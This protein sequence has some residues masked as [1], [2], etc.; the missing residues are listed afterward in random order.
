MHHTTKTDTATGAIV[1]GEGTRFRIW[2]P[3]S[4]SVEI[5]V[6]RDDAVD[7][8]DG[9]DRVEIH[10]LQP[11]AGGWFGAHVPGVAAGDRY[12]LR[13]NGTDTSPDP[14][15]RFQPDGVHGASEVVDLNAF[16]W[17][18]GN[19]RGRGLDEMVI[20]ELHVGTA[21]PAG[22][23]DALIER[24]PYFVE[25]GVTALEI[26]PVAEFP[27]DRNWGYDGVYLFAPTRA[28]GGPDA[29]RRFIDA[30]HGHGLAVIL[31][32]VY[33]H[34]G[35]DGNY[36]PAMT[37]GRI[38]TERHHTPWGAAV[39]Y[40]D[41][42]ADAVRAIVLDNVRQWVRDYHVDGLRLDATHSILDS[43]DSHILK[44][45]AATAHS[46]GRTVVVIAEDERNEQR[47]VLPA[48]DGGYGLD[49]VWA[50]DT[51][52]I[53]R[54]LVAG[55]DGGY[56]S[57]YEGT[58]SELAR[59]LRH[60]WL[61][62]GADAETTPAEGAGGG[63]RAT[64]IEPPRFVHC[65]Q[66][67]DQV[68]NRAFGERLNHQVDLS[69]YRAVSALLL[70]T[71]YT[72]LL[73]MGQEWAATTPFL[74]FTDHPEELGRLVTRGRREEF[75]GFSQF[76]DEKLRDRIPDPQAATTFAASKLDWQEPERQPHA[77]VL[78]LYR[79]LLGLRQ[80][81]PALRVRQRDRFDVRDI[82]DIGDIGD[83]RDNPGSALALRRSSG[84][85]H[86]LLLVVSFDGEFSLDTGALEVTRAD[87]GHEWRV[88]LWTE[89]DRFGGAGR[90][91]SLDGGGTHLLLP[92]TGA[93]LL[94][95]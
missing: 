42:G 6:Q 54:R 66:N 1:E 45:I 32:V 43:S 65:I 36:L 95:S 50:D 85:G 55:D 88:L 52:H 76:T 63:G 2:A 83:N 73:W 74:Y 71:P 23:F 7:H 48:S 31:D 90:D 78:R 41:E 93:V 34:F 46:F 51:H 67:H 82:G 57:T 10:E 64:D 84:A 20:H 11:E 47:I 27:G 4:D 59:A 69:V 26:M 94:E 12:R 92:S 91:T 19:W 89:E 38:F 77:G 18:D 75:S 3:A 14:L 15:S 17:T 44:E 81:H 30:S 62:R 79:E 29:M 87:H 24:L 60:G 22:T 56:F 33:N 39:N 86:D 72:P 35:P 21:T 68:G 61:E 58:T 28:Y 53:T 70:L 49:A 25:L 80:Q 5:V 37:G 13:L 16:E 40:D 8:A 9:G